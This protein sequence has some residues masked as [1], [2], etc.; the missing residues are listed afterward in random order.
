MAAQMSYVEVVFQGDP[1]AVLQ[2]L[3]S[4]NVYIYAMFLSSNIS[5]MVVSDIEA[6]I[7]TSYLRSMNLSYS[8]SSVVVIPYIPQVGGLI[9]VLKD[10]G[11]VQY[12]YVGFDNAIIARLL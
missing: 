3:D 10:L 4:K 7:L 2:F 8:V 6:H 11:Q 9:S 12:A 5:S 1:I